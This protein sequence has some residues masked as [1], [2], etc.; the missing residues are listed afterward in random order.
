MMA[1]IIFTIKPHSVIDV[2]TNSSTELFVGKNQSKQAMDELIKEIYPN[3]LYEYEELLT[4]D[5]LTV[6]QLNEYFDYTCSA[7][8]F[9]SSKAKMPIIPGFTFEELYEEDGRGVAWNGELQYILKNN[10]I[11]PDPDPDE[12][13]LFLPS[14]FITEENFEEMKRKLDPNKEML[15]LYSIDENPNWDYQKKLMTIMDRT[16]LG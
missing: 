16:H 5:D 1:K 11:D 13:P 10:Y 15:F 7:H 3:Y 14:Q 12:D 6:D 4:I 8:C 2:I 9:P